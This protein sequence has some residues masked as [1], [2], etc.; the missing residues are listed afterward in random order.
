MNNMLPKATES[1]IAA[2][3][4]D[5]VQQDTK[6]LVTRSRQLASKLRKDHPDLSK[7]I[8]AIVSSSSLR[9]SEGQIRPVPVDADSRQKLLREEYPM[10]LD[11]EPIWPVS[12]R[13]QLHSLVLEQSQAAVLEE[14]GLTPIRS[15]LM[16]GPPGCGKTTTAGWVAQQLDLPLLTLDLATVMSSYL[17]KTGSNIRAVLDHAQEAPCVL[18]LDEFDAI[19]K[20]RDD[21][22]DVGELKRLVTV[23]LQAID[24]W[25]SGSLLVAATNHGELLDP[26]VWRRFDLVVDFPA[27]T[28]EQVASYLKTEIDPFIAEWLSREIVPE[29]IALL[30]NSFKSIRKKILLEQRSLNEVLIEQFSLSVMP[31]ELENIAKESSVLSLTDQGLSQRKISEMTGLSRPVV[32]KIQ[33]KSSQ[34]EKV[35]G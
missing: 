7:K 18:L 9:G 2:I 20:R 15:L 21:D 4:S 22:S 31:S 5:G 24:D 13:E 6:S 33:E 11:A 27:P 17:G 23:L 12:I 35:N 28:K 25:P 26:A 30:K 16:T 29:S 19:A 8:G 10:L 34:G 14:A 1:L 32:K 3:I